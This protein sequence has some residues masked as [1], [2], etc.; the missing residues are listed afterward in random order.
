MRPISFPAL[1][2][3][4]LTA[5]AVLITSAPSFAA[6]IVVDSTDDALTVDGNCTL[7]EAVKAAN[8]NGAVDGCAAGD[9]ADA[10][11]VPLELPR[12]C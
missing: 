8:V 1:C 2:V 11:E 7:R 12:R 6:T 4:T 5:L 3:A 10:I 9:G